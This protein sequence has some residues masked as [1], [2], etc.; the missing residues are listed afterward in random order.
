M[1]SNLK[2]VHKIKLLVV[3]LNHTH[4]NH[5]ELYLFE[6]PLY[7]YNILKTTLAKCLYSLQHNVLQQYDYSPSRSH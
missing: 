6:N 7:T 2:L 3:I 1:K 5:K 4:K